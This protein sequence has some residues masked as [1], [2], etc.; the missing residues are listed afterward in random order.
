VHALSFGD[1]KIAT[2]LHG[3]ERSQL[4]AATIDYIFSMQAH[5]REEL[6]QG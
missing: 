4:A 6:C 2:A 3:C 5:S 1:T